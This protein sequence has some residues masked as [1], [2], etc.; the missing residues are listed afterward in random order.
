MTIDQTATCWPVMDTDATCTDCRG[1]PRPTWTGSGR[2][3][4]EAV[5]GVGGLSL[6]P[7]W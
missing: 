2:V 1:S 4:I 5:P 3:L 6:E 7:E